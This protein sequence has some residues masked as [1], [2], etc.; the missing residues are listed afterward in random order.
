[1]NGSGWAGEGIVRAIFGG[2]PEDSRRRKCAC[3]GTVRGPEI[4]VT[5]VQPVN[6]LAIIPC[7]M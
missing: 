7:V 5:L 2:R 6:T 3:R 1:V 4:D